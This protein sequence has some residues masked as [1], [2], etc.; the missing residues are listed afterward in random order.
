MFNKRNVVFQAILLVFVGH[1]QFLGGNE[2]E[3]RI[4]MA[5]GHN[6]GMHS[7]SVFQV[8]YKI[9]VEVL[10]STL[11]LDD[12]IEIKECLRRMLVSSISSIY[13]WHRCEFAGIKCCAFEIMAH[14]DDIAVVADH[15]DG[16]LQRFSFGAGSDFGVSKSDDACSQT[17]GCSLER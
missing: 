9:D 6:Q 2:M 3:G 10:K 5:H 12:G 7:A 1:C 17:V 14:D 11:G 13:H 16:V 8:A 15:H 4:E